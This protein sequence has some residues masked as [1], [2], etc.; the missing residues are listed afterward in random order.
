[1]YIHLKI[2]YLLS[3]LLFLFRFFVGFSLLAPLLLPFTFILSS[4]NVIFSF[5][6]LSYY[7]W[8]SACFFLTL[9]FTL[10]VLLYALLLFSSISLQHL[11]RYFGDFKDRFGDGCDRIGFVDIVNVLAKIKPPQKMAVNVVLSHRYARLDLE[12]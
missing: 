8:L 4:F 5:S 1:M 11:L 9:L 12:K 6:F 7:S 2:V 3:L 10:L